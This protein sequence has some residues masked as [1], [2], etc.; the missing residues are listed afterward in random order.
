MLGRIDP[1][2]VVGGVDTQRSI[3]GLRT[4]QEVEPRIPVLQ[5]EEV[6]Q[7]QPERV[8]VALNPDSILQQD[9]D[10]DN[11]R[12]EPRYQALV[13]RMEADS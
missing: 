12:E 6:V 3:D 1:D 4:A 7:P 5:V 10:L 13:E 2:L 9:S 11:L 8:P